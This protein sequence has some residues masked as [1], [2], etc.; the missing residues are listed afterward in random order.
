MYNKIMI[1]LI[2]LQNPKNFKLPGLNYICYNK[3]IGE[4]LR[5]NHEKIKFGKLNFIASNG[6]EINLQEQFIAVPY[7][8]Y[9]YKT[10]KI[11]I[12]SLQILLILSQKYNINLT[13]VLQN[14]LNIIIKLLW[15]KNHED[16]QLSK[17][18]EKV[19][20]VKYQV[21]NI[22][23]TPNQDKEKYLKIKIIFQKYFIG[24][25]NPCLF[26]QIK[27]YTTF[28]SNTIQINNTQF[29]KIK[30][31]YLP[32]T[33][34][35]N[36]LNRNIDQ[37]TLK[38]PSLSKLNFTKQIKYKSNFSQEC[39]R[40][41][42]PFLAVTLRHKDFEFIIAC[43]TTSLKSGNHTKK[44]V[45]IKI[46]LKICIYFQAYHKQPTTVTLQCTP[47]TVLQLCSHCNTM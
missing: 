25:K 41:P 5:F 18:Q 34:M 47:T 30:T 29:Q 9:N 36:T 23:T 13:A 22:L 27:L 46:N 40:T 32:K 3:K 45:E 43:S 8:K 12:D 31:Y 39:N 44:A 14:S 26:T 10:I 28:K 7:N 2:I 21:L 4:V 42:S 19:F 37:I 11:Q 15:R 35:K 6:A 20:E 33:N 38:N 1:L 24:K 17:N 16:Y